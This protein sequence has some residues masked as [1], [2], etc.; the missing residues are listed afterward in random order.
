MS[1]FLTI[2]AIGYIMVAFVFHHMLLK[3]WKKDPLPPDVL[4]WLI[5]GV[6]LVSSLFWLPAVAIYVLYEFIKEQRGL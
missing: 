1:I 5:G 6:L 2:L 4:R 3:E